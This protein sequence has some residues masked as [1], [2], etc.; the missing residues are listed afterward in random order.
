MEDIYE[1]AYFRIGFV[2]A[3][4]MGRLRYGALVGRS[5]LLNQLKRHLTK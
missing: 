5:G 3:P 2:G 4:P 1:D